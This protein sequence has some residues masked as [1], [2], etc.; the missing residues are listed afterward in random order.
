MSFV[1]IFCLK[2]QKQ[3]LTAHEVYGVHVM[4]NGDMEMF[5]GMCNCM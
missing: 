5:T 2:K 3:F 4:N 1:V